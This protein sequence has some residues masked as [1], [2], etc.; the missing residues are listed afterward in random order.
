M[1]YITITLPKLYTVLQKHG[2]SKYNALL[3]NYF[4]KS[5]ALHCILSAVLY[6]ENLTLSEKQ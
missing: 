5:N 4:G 3:Y 1:H 2:V 6:E